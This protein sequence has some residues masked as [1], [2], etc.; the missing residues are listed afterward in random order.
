MNY[1]QLKETQKKNRESS[2]K[3]IALHNAKFATKKHEKGEAFKKGRTSGNY[4]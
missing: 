3:R 2:A 4:D 1:E